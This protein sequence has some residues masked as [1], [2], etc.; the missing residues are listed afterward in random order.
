MIELLRANRFVRFALLYGFV[1]VI[2]LSLFGFILHRI[3]G[4]IREDTG[5]LE[6]REDITQS[7]GAL[8]KDLRETADARQ[9][10]FLIRPHPQELVSL[11]RG[12]EGAAARSFIEQKASAQPNVVPDVY[13]SPVVKYRVRLLGPWEKVEAYLSELAKLQSLVRVEAIQMST[14][15][16]GD[17]LQQGQTDL[18]FAVAVLDPS[19]EIPEPQRARSVGSVA[20]PPT[21]AAAGASPSPASRR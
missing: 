4:R 12:I 14:S 20:S 13:A 21:P 6:R 1:S 5:L 17:L 11:I 9:A 3:V 8:L 2:L 7:F 18:S 19:A 15:L 16:D 10:L